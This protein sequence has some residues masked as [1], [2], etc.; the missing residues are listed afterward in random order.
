MADRF[1]A[2]QDVLNCLAP[3]AVNFHISSQKTAGERKLLLD[4]FKTAARALMTNARCLTEG[5]DVP[6]IDCVVFAD[7]KQSATD[8]VQASGRAMR[9]YKGKKY[10]YIVV[11]IVVPENTEFAEF[12]E[13]TAFRTIG[14]IIT[15]LSVH[16][17]RIVDEL[18]AIHHGRN[19]K[20]KIIK[21]DG[22]VPVGLR[23]SLDRFA[24][25]ITLKMW[26]SVARVN[27]RPFEEA[28]AFVRKLGLASQQ[29]WHSYCQTGKKPADIPANASRVYSADWINW[30]DWLGNGNRPANGWR[31]FEEARSFVRRL[32]L[33]SHTEWVV[34]RKSDK[35][36]DDIP[37]TP[38]SVYSAEWI[39][40]SDWLGTKPLRPNGGWRPFEEARAFVRNLGLES[41]AEWL[42]YC[43]SDKKP[44]DIPVSVHAVYS[45]DWTSMS[46][47]LGTKPLRPA[48]GWRSFKGA[49]TF[50]RKLG[51]AN[52]KEWFVYCQSDKKPADIPTIPGRLYSAEWINWSDWLGTKPYHR[53]N[54][55]WRPFKQAR[56][57]VRKLGL[58]SN[59]E[60]AIYAKSSK[61]PENIPTTPDRVYSA[62]W[63]SWAD[64]LDTKPPRPAN[65]WRT[66]KEARTFVRKLGLASQAEWFAYCKSDKKPDDIPTSPPIVYSADW[67]NW[68]DWLGGGLRKSGWRS[69][70]KARAFIRKLGFTGTAEWKAYCKSNKKPDDIPT[71]PNSVYSAEW[72]SMSDWLGTKPLRPNGGWRPFE[73]ARAFVRNLGLKSHT[74]WRA[75]SKSDK[76]PNDI[77]TDPYKAYSA[78]WI[79]SSDWL[80]NGK[81]MSGW[82][83]FKE[84]RT[85]V[86][87]LGLKSQAEWRAYSKSEKRPDDIPAGPYHMYSADWISWGDWLGN[88]RRVGAGVH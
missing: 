74:E 18:H 43:K 10:G 70:K 49:R 48:N 81:R 25:A 55:G 54:G 46:D 75:Y 85:F 44:D 79:S 76:R 12:A 61:R 39:S 51:L 29:E 37:T 52:Q 35:K 42:A 67:I 1:R 64:W 21:I 26:E 38:N 53:P 11:P 2:Q 69:F 9:L 4:E 17:T 84:A 66:F 7:P 23:M 22:K 56:A 33:K 73:E 40:M 80:G 71:N 57:F 88:G 34:Y 8:I 31:S 20:G 16:D 14:R 59:A 36:P 41:Y 19:A 77:P 78:D 50:V 72:I 45:A 27:R 6:A 47:W 82:R 58:K 30:S 3:T 24:D 15:A 5:V 87:K 68:F 65:G 60:W 62:D 86:R 63:I 28:R 32:N 13:T 83:S